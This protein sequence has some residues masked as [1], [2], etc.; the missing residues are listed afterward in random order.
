MIKDRD[1]T[2]DIAKGIFIIL[3]VLG[4]STFPYTDVIYWFH[5]PAFFIVS[6]TLYKENSIK[7]AKLT[8]TLFVPFLVYIL[9]NVFV[10]FFTN[11]DFNELDDFIML[12]GK[13]LYNGKIIGGVYWYIPV[14][15]LTKIVFD[16]AH[17]LMKKYVW[18]LMVLSYVAAHLISIN[19]V[20]DRDN[21]ANTNLTLVLPWDIDV[22]LIAVWYFFIGVLIKKYG[23]KMYSNYKVILT[24]FAISGAF[25]IS[26]Y[27]FDINYFFDMKYSY[28]KSILLDTTVPIVFT[29]FFLGLSSLIARMKSDFGLSWA[30]SKSLYIMFLHIPLGA[31]I[32]QIENYILFTLVGVIVPLLFS[33]LIEKNRYTTFL[34]TGRFK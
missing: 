25:L 1:K 26:N 27:L 33:L 9:I 15:F 5:M 12:L 2:L 6:G 10:R 34:F 16:I 8:V 28:Y 22:V 20:P 19:L 31:N 21:F 14:F 11:P 24:T 29:I 23:K 18:I 13:H 32:L 3:V 7:L 4:H 30:G 17:K